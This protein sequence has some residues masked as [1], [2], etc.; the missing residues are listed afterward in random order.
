MI[1]GLA[2]RDE[3]E[4]SPCPEQDAL[5]QMFGFLDGVL[6]RQG[7]FLC[8]KN[9]Y[10]CDYYLAMLARWTRKMAKPAVTHPEIRR[11]VR[12]CLAR[13]A[14]ARMLSAQGIDQAA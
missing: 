14:Y 11:L 5:D 6:S 2:R 10:V 12:T 1:E 9:F 4:V 8:G 13:P 7:P 3:K